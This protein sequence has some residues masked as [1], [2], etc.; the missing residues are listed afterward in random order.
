METP[1]PIRRSGDRA[2]RDDPL[3]GQPPY[4]GRF[5]PSPTGLLHLGSLTT[6]VASYL[7]ALKARG[8]WLVRIDDIDPPREVEGAA[9]A[10]LRTLEALE[11]HWDRPVLYQSTRLKAYR[12]VAE[13]LLDSARAF[14]CECSRKDVLE[15]T[16]GDARYP[17]TCRSAGLAGPAAIRVRVDGTETVFK[18]RLQGAV[19]RLIEQTDGDY[20]IYRRDDLPAYH[21]ASVLDDA[22]LG[23]TDVVRGIDL[24]GCTSIHVHLQNCLG[25]PEPRYWHLPVVVNADGTK[26]SKQTGAAEI[27]AAAAPGYAATA[28]ELLGLEVPPS[29]A[30]ANP[31]ELWTWAAAHWDIAALG[32]RSRY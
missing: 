10:I 1:I 29:L 19:F 6:A 15:A 20:V 22:D 21:L 16:G 11:L 5:A 12:E 25:L 32:G 2:A 31:G 3:P 18:D 14:Y 4:V 24:I 17:G 28:L 23:V 7:H 13:S 26:L 8:E 30:G 9:D 27:E